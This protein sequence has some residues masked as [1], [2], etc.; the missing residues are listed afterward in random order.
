MALGA[1]FVIT[2]GFIGLDLLLLVAAAFLFAII[3]S[4]PY[5]V[6]IGTLGVMIIGRSF[7]AVIDLLTYNSTV[8]SHPEGYRASVSL[9]GYILPDLGAL[10][11]RMVALYGRM[12]F[13]PPDWPLLVVST[14]AYTCGLLG[15]AT[16]ALQRKLFA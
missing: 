2:I 3:T 7:A 13:M 5:F 1:P 10:D 11:V 12:E 9:L 8:V 14:L 4:T 15:L 16:W 6:L